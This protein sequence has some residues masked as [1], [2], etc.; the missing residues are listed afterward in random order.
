MTNIT[1]PDDHEDDLVPVKSPSGGIHWVYGR[2]QKYYN[3]RVERYLT[4]CLFT[5]VGDLQDL[6]RIIAMELMCWRWMV[7]VSQQH[8]YWN[9]PIEEK[10]LNKYIKE[11]SAE[12]RAIK[13]SLGIDKVTRDKTKGE[14]S[15]S[16]YI[17]NLKIRAKEFGIMRETQLSKALEL[18]NDLI[19]R[20]TLMDNCTEDER[21]E[22]KCGVEDIMT[23]LR[24]EAFPQFAEIDD[25]FKQNSQ[26]FWIR[27]Q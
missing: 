13:S 6:D 27:D 16:K 15:V 24:E 22:L 25:H 2:E 7:W 11:T 18:F 17:E 8:D 12:L 3:E 14:D 23:W 1:A 26:R 19:G 5:N 9:D 21:I 4:D 20:V 10:D